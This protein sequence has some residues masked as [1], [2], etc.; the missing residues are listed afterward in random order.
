MITGVHTKICHK[1][2][3][4]KVCA[5]DCD[6]KKR[7]GGVTDVPLFKT[8]AGTLLKRELASIFDMEVAFTMFIRDL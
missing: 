8:N 4:I 3:I 1:I 6:E 2:F 7:G 5:S